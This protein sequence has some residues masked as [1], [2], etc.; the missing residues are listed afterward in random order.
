[1]ILLG[2]LLE[3]CY[4]NSIVLKGFSELPPDSGMKLTAV[5]CEIFQAGHK[6]VRVI[7]HGCSNQQSPETGNTTSL[8]LQT[9]S[10]SGTM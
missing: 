4:C 8:T 7:W 2:N 10:R 3:F 6:D 9:S 5:L 1:M